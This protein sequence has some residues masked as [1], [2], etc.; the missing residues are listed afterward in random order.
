MVE[1]GRGNGELI[2]SERAREAGRIIESVKGHLL[3]SPVWYKLFERYSAGE[4]DEFRTHI[5]TSVDGTGIGFVIFRRDGNSEGLRWRL[6][7][8][9]EN[10]FDINVGRVEFRQGRLGK[11]RWG[12]ISISTPDGVSGSLSESN[13]EQAVLNADRFL[14]RLWTMK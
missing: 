14:R 9:T 8:Y 4:V 12:L 2:P 7:T 10:G 3:R 5:G 13:N 6:M 11:D 1:A